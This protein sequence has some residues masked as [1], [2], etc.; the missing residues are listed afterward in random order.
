VPLCNYLFWC[1][2]EHGSNRLWRLLSN[3]FCCCRNNKR[4]HCTLSISLLSML[5]FCPRTR[6]YSYN[7]FNCIFFIHIDQRKSPW[8]HSKI[9]K[10]ILWHQF[11]NSCTFNCVT[12]FTSKVMFEPLYSCG[13]YFLT[14]NTLHK[15]FLYGI[16][17]PSI[18][19]SRV[20]WSSLPFRINS[21]CS[22]SKGQYCN[23]LFSERGSI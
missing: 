14:E 21:L 23:S 2:A 17:P 3:W 10:H 13:D 22:Q 6:F 7:L 8:I 15:I 16:W 18:I 20:L 12:K 1:L 11:R 9:S 19:L 4:C 5:A